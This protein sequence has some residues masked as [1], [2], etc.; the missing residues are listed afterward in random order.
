MSKFED[1]AD[2]PAPEGA[3]REASEAEPEHDDGR[4]STIHEESEAEL[5]SDVLEVWHAELREEKGLLEPT[6]L[7]DIFTVPTH[8]VPDQSVLVTVADEQRGHLPK[9][10][11][12][13]GP[14]IEETYSAPLC[15][16]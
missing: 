4:L 3:P 14:D 9:W 2:A 13:H 15:T 1:L 6:P 8:M 12:T 11:R 7:E 16:M 5:E 10:G